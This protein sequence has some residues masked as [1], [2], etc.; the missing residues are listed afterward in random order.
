MNEEKM[1]QRAKELF[2]AMH[3]IHMVMIDEDFVENWIPGEG[4]TVKKCLN[5]AFFL[6]DT[7]VND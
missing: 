3:K 6:I 2:E 4:E 7:V 1:L 5:D